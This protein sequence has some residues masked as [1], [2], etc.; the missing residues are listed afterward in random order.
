MTPVPEEEFFATALWGFGAVSLAIAG[1]LFVVG[2]P[3]GSQTS[4]RGWLAVNGQAAWVVME[5]VS[6]AAL[7]YAYLL[8]TS[9]VP[10]LIR[11]ADPQISSDPTRFSASNILVVLWLVHYAQRAIL[12]PLRQQSRKPMHVGIMLTAVVFNTINGY[13]NGRWLGVFA[14]VEYQETIVPAHHRLAECLCGMTLFVGGMAGNIHHDNILIELRR[15][16][17]LGTSRYSIPYGGM[18]AFVSCPHFLCEL[19]EWLGFALLSNSPAA[20]VFLLNAVCN[21]LPRAY[22][23]HRWYRLKFPKY[24][25]QRK[26]L[27]PFII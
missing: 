10:H 23:I 2:S 14:P 22:F 18:F 25:Q 1:A 9:P 12:Y 26:A 27:I 16:K 8:R 6:P 13:L 17:R 15:T 21:L 24:P 4:Y 20:W 19:I 7:L 5:L 3:Y 11:A